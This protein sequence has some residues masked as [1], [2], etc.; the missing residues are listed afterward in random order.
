[1]QLI[2]LHTVNETILFSFLVEDELAK[3]VF[4]LPIVLFLESL[5]GPANALFYFNFTLDSA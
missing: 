4:I 3:Y 2:C 5:T 1:M